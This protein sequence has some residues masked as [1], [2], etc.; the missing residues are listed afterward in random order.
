MLNV[1]KDSNEIVHFGKHIFSVN[2]LSDLPLLEYWQS[3]YLSAEMA[4]SNGFIHYT[5]VL[6]TSNFLIQRKTIIKVI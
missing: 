2:N 4:S 5:G 6:V 1:H 3:H